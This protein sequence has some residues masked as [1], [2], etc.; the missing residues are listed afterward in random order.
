MTVG[1][2]IKQLQR[3][4]ACCKVYM[5]SDAEGNT[6]HGLD[7]TEFDTQMAILWPDDNYLEYEDLLEQV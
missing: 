7:S 5:S 2:L 4:P 6:F 1:E 3:L